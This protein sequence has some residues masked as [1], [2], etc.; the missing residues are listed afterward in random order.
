[1]TGF[2]SGFQQWLERSIGVAAIFF[3]A[4]APLLA[5]TPI[6]SNY[7]ISTI[8]TQTFFLGIAAQA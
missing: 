2:G 1:M 6:M 3:V 4:A 7:F 5:P 8:L